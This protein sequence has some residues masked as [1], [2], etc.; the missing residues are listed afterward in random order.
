[1]DYCIEVRNMYEAIEQAGMILYELRL[2][3]LLIFGMAIAGIIRGILKRM[4]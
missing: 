1:M 3:L 4:R 2:W